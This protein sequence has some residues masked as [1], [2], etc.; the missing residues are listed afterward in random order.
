MSPNSHQQLLLGG[1]SGTDPFFANVISL[2]HF[3]GTPGDTTYIDQIATRT[4][5]FGAPAPTLSNVQ[6]KFG[7]TSLLVPGAGNVAVV[8]GAGGDAFGSSDFTIEFWFNPTTLTGV[9][10]ILDFRSANPDAAPA[11]Y[12]DG[13]TI[14]YFTANAIQITGTAI[15][16]GAWTFIALSRVSG[17]TRMFFDG[18]Q[19]GSTYVDSNVYTNVHM[20]L[21]SGFNGAQFINGFIDEYRVTSGVG[22]YTSNFTPPTLAFPNS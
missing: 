10:I 17:N 12:F 11:I 16:T 15:S 7:P 6:V 1:A 21:G 13:T 4:W 18:I 3:D 22:R 19:V 8:S 9:M 5:G 20:L 2:V 14:N